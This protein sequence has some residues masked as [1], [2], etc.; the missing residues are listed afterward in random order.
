MQ[1]FLDIQPWYEYPT[2]VT[3]FNTVAPILDQRNFPD[4]D[5]SILV[6]SRIEC[7]IDTQL[8]ATPENVGHSKTT[9][10]H[11]TLMLTGRKRECYCLKVEMTECK[12]ATAAVGLRVN[13]LVRLP[14]AYST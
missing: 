13:R 12:V 7:G 2:A 6:S 3:P 9:L 14:T 1:G 8:R 11:S 10:I 4:T 5:N